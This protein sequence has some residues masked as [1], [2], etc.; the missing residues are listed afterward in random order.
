VLL[1]YFVAVCSLDS[2]ARQKKFLGWWCFFMVLISLL[3]LASLVGF[4]PLNAVPTI[5]GVMKG[6]LILNLSVFN[7]PNALAHS[8][9]PALPLV[10]YLIFWRRVAMKA[11]IILLAIPLCCIFFTQSKGAY[12]CGF[13]TILA[14]LTFGRSKTIQVL[15]LVFAIGFGYGLLYKLPRMNELNRAKDDPAIQGRVAAFQFGLTLM[16]THFFGIGLGNFE[17]TFQREGPTEKIRASR[18]VTSNHASAK[19]FVYVSTHYSKA[20]H[21][22]YNQNGAELGYVGLYLF[23]GI[24]YC[25]IRTLLL[26]ESKDNDEERIRRALFATVVAYAVSSW[27]VDF[28][29]RPTFF[30]FAAAISA[31]HRHLL[32]KQE[33]DGRPVVEQNAPPVLPWMRPRPLAVPGLPIPGLAAA[34]YPMT[35]TAET[36]ALPETLQAGVSPNRRALAWHKP[37]G[38][39]VD[40][41]RKRFIWTRLGIIDFV[42]I[43]ILTWAAIQY[44][45]HL[46]AT[47]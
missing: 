34:G 20:T 1:F 14:T 42:I 24:L 45:K 13:A 22:A 7:N 9:V 5:Q 41:L 23:V 16:R 47:M 18:V 40:T 2:I 32:R 4:D 26:V 37:H 25:C 11:G 27:M 19:R 38:S 21:C 30:M 8:V 12:L 35:M 17:E 43:W 6:R 3:A 15:I 29:Y 10:Y 33:D 36:A 46:I 39:L 31:F 28:C 44:W